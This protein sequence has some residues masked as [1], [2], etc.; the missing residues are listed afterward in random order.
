MKLVCVN[1][2]VIEVR[3]T[4]GQYI[5]KRA[6]FSQVSPNVSFVDVFLNYFFI[7]RGTRI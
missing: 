2:F 1:I 6:E 7:F 3:I 4:S 5:L